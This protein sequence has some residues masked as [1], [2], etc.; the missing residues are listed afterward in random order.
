MRNSLFA[1]SG[2]EVTFLASV[3]PRLADLV[4]VPVDSPVVPI[5]GCVRTALVS[6]REGSIFY[7]VAHIALIDFHFR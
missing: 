5:V 6:A 2:S 1:V 4:H 7:Y 3:L